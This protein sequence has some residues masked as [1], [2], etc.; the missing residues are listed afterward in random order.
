MPGGQLPVQ[1][2]LGQTT[3]KTS[4]FP[5][6]TRCTNVLPG[7]SDVRKKE[8]VAAGDVVKLSITILA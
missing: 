7:K 6:S 5:D 4:I 8:G 1:A 2:R 3:W